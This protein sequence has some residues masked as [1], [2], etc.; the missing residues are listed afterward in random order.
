MKEEEEFVAVSVATERKSV[1]L[2]DS[3]RSG[4]GV[5]SEELEEILPRVYYF[6]EIRVNSR[7][8]QKGF[9]KLSGLDMNKKWP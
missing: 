9:E 7:I 1:A 4:E 3:Y 8:T 6:E 5:E 2:R